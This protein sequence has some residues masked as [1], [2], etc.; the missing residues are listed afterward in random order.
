MTPLP[1]DHYHHHRRY[2][3][4]VDSSSDPTP[5]GDPSP[6]GS[7]TSSDAVVPFTLE[8]SDADLD[9]LRERLA[10]TRWPDAETV[11]DWSQ[12]IPLAYTREVC[13]YWLDQYDWRPREQRLNRFPQFRT[14]LGG[15]GDEALGIHFVHVRSPEPDA[16]PLVLTH[17]WPGST[18]EFME[19][20]GPLTDPVTHGDDAADAFDVVA[21]SLPGFGF[22]D[23]PTRH[24]WGVDRFAAAW[25]ELMVRL[26]Y[27]RYLAPA[28]AILREQ[29]GRIR[30]VCSR[31]TW[32]PSGNAA[33]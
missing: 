32:A 19:V 8:V 23:K 30:P 31:R 26:G 25:D 3:S 16:M 9:D 24:G 15:G 4:D 2:R 29:R 21:P 13:E 27:E 1:P 17:G 6:S 18:V 11:E 7:G 10:H 20:I 14:T 5:S 33:Q 12:G 28:P 22:S